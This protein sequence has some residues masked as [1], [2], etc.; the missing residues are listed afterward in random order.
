MGN[1]VVYMLLL[2][3]LLFNLYAMFTSQRRKKKASADMRR[4]QSELATKAVELGKKEHLKFDASETYMNDKG[5]VIFATIDKKKR[6]LGIFY[7][8]DS[9]LI[10]YDDMK[11]IEVVSETD[12]K[13]VYSIS[14][15][16][17]CPERILSYP[18][19]TEKR[20]KKS[21]ISNFITKDAQEFVTKLRHLQ[22]S[23]GEVPAG[24]E[25]EKN[26]DDGKAAEG[27]AE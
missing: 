24:S 12:D 4:Q 1:Y 2:A 26:E 9:H 22:T 8:E 5:R 27:E 25:D 7:D 16:I 14:V 3:I 18:F 10:P 17:T 6:V 13:Y 21:W 23:A 11:S 19:A 15:E 20:R